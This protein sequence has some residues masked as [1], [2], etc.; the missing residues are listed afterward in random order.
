[1]SAN[2]NANDYN[3]VLIRKTYTNILKYLNI[4]RLQ[5]MTKISNENNKLIDIIIETRNNIR[6]Y[7]KY[8]SKLYKISDDIRNKLSEQGIGLIDT[9]HDTKWFYE[10]IN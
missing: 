8:D 3:I 9:V 10:K 1:M 6:E 5:Y 7:A 2:V 4:F